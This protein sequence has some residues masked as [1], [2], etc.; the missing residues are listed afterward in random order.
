VFRSLVEEIRFLQ[1]HG[2]CV[3]ASGVTYEIK[4]R[5]VKILGDNLGLNSLLGYN[6]SFSANH[7]CRVCRVHKQSVSQLF[8]ELF[9]ED[10]SLS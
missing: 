1:Q 10:K 8:A 6:E 7:Y 2:V 9:A 5:M 4:F 3:N